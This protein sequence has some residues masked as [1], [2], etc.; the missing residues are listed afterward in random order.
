MNSDPVRCG[1]T[2]SD[3][4]LNSETS[5]SYV[6]SRISFSFFF[7]RHKETQRADLEWLLEK[8]QEG[9]FSETADSCPFALW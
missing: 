6:F 4:P 8:F 9:Y 7:W 2:Q 1:L 3:A 5:G